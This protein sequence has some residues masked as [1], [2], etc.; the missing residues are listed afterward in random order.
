SL[1]LLQK[2]DSKNGLRYANEYIRIS[3]S[4]NLIQKKSY[5]KYARIEYE[6]SRVEN[7]NADLSKKNFIILIVSFVLIL[8]FVSVIFWRSFKHKNREL[9]LL[10][11]QQN[12]N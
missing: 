2:A 8:F 7:E 9:R 6:T 1:E 10:K 3:D 11:M 5:D 4:L 12:A